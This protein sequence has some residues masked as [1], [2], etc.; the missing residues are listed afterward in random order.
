MVLAGRPVRAASVA[1]DDDGWRATVPVAPDIE[2]TL[3]ADGAQVERAW[4]ELW[5]RPSSSEVGVAVVARDGEPVGLARIPN[6]DCG[7]HGCANAGRQLSA[8]L[9]ADETI[10]LLDL[11]ERLPSLGPLG[12]DAATWSADPPPPEATGEGWYN[13]HPRTGQRF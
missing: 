11:L 9:D 5:A 7:E 1:A 6:C 2:L 4:S 12:R 10:A 8:H 13:F 3:Q